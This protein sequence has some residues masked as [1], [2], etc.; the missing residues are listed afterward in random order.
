MLI[1][2]RARGTGE[3]V[4]TID[5]DVQRECDVVPHQLEIRGAQQMRDVS[6]GAGKEIIDAQDVRASCDQPVAQVAAQKSGAPG[7]QNIV[8]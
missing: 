1:M 5:L 7:H 8:F 3:V 2:N 6:L 4:Y